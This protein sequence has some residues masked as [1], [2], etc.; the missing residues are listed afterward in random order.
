MTVEHIE[1]GASRDTLVQLANDLL[2]TF[3]GTASDREH[4][5]TAQTEADGGDVVTIRF[6]NHDI[7]DDEVPAGAVYVEVRMDE[8]A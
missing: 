4:T 1:I 5:V 3:A 6:S 8:G 2:S 7:E